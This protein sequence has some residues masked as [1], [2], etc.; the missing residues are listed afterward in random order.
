MADAFTRSQTFRREGFRADARRL[1]QEGREHQ[2]TMEALNKTACEMIFKEKNQG[3][4]LN[5]V[6]LHGLYVKEAE[7]KVEEA[8]LA[9][10]RRGD[11]EVRFI[12]GQ[13]LHSSDGAKLKPALV[14]YIKQM[15]GRSVHTDPRNAGVLVVPLRLNG[16]GDEGPKK[17][18]QSK[19]KA[20]KRPVL[21]EFQSAV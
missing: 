2:Q 3:R 10:E 7:Q 15:P 17:H 1:S 12:V 4:E 5:E 11:N 19:R 6:D 13:G 14:Y 20:K 9:A 21:H 18:R 8:V 16:D